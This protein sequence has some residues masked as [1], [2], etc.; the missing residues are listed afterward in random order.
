[1]KRLL[2]FALLLVST[3]SV[4]LHATEGALGHAITGFQATSYAGL[5]PPEPGFTWL[6]G[7]EYYSG[8]I[9]ASRE[10]PLTGG[11]AALGLKAEFQ[12]LTATGLYVWKTA[13]SSWNFASMMTFPLAYADVNA[14]T[15]LGSFNT[16]HSDNLIG[17]YDLLFAPVIASHHFSQTQHISFGLYVSAPT[18]DYKPGRLA[19]LSL[20][21]WVFSPTLGYTALFDQGSLEWST[22]TAAD[23]YTKDDATNYQN[24]T[25]F[26]I[27]S[28]LVKRFP[29]GWGVGAVAGWIYQLED[30]TGPIADRLNGFKG[31]SLAFGPMVNYLK[32]WEGGQAEFS[33]RWLHEF[34]VSNRLKGN[35]GMLTATISL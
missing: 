2:A 3:M 33:L 8:S 7:Y 10:V 15:R 32:K 16:N 27:D 21:T 14:N 24:G 1:M 28:L 26:R 13:P 20:N 9:S 6:Y 34:D 25:V 29:T 18:G 11:G 4:S 31:H 23:F 30:D 22:S 19:N 35:G 17:P 5:I 12:L